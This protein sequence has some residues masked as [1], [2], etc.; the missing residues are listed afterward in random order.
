MSTVI[1]LV[2]Y[3]AQRKRIK[4]VL[5]VS[6]LS[7]FMAAIENAESFIEVD[8]Q[9][10]AGES[11]EPSVQGI[12]H[13][14]CLLKCQRCLEVFRFIFTAN[15]SLIRYKSEFQDPPIGDEELDPFVAV[16]DEVE[17]EAIL[18][19]ELLLALP[20]FPKHDDN[21]CTFIDKKELTPAAK[22]SSTVRVSSI[23]T[24]DVSKPTSYEPG[25]NPKSKNKNSLNKHK[26]FEETRKSLVGLS[27]LLDSKKSNDKGQ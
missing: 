15:I 6:N 26:A 1:N 18:E 2:E 22:Q 3:A 24:P 17:L 21:T 10:A 19:D 11:G 13:G 9:F 23:T 5:D 16:E 7:R 8:L 14:Y 27:I 20:D 25:S 4:Y 12:I